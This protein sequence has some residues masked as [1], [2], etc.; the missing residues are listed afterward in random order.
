VTA[1]VRASELSPQPADRSRRV[2]EAAYIATATGQLNEAARLLTDARQA[3]GTA[4]GSIFAAAAE[5]VYLTFGES[6]PGP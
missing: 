1:L 3:S 6:S 4:T 5:A 2:A